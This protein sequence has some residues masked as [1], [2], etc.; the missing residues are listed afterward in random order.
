M[1]NKEKQELLHPAE[2]YGG[3]TVPDLSTHCTEMPLFT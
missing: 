3:Y 2:Y 1:G